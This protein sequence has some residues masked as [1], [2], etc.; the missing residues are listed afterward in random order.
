MDPDISD[1]LFSAELV[2]VMVLFWVYYILEVR[3]NSRSE[4][5]Y[6]EPAWEGA[7]SDGVLFYYPY[8]TLVFGCWR[9]RRLGRWC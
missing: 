1:R 2:L 8:S 5:W 3:R 9:Y 6:D 7:V 4:G